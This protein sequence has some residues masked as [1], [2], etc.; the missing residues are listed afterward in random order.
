MDKLKNITAKKDN[1]TDQG[2]LERKRF[3]FIKNQNFFLIIIIIV[4]SVIVSFI[5]PN[6]FTYRNISNILQQVSVLGIATM[7]MGLL[8]LAGQLDL[9]IGA[10]MGLVGVI[11]VKMVKAGVSVELSVLAVLAIATFCGF[12]NGIIVAKSNVMPLIITLG[13]LYVYYGLALYIS[14][15][16]PNALG[17]YFR[18]LG[19][20][21]LGPKNFAIP[22]T[23]VVFL[24]I[25]LFAFAMNKYTKY[26]RRLNAIGGNRLTAYLAGINVDMH[27]ISLY[28]L[29]GL[30]MGLAGLVLTSRLGNVRAA[31][32]EG[33]ELKALAAV[34][35]GGITFEGGRGSL[36]GAFFG[37]VLL[38]VIYNAM[39]IIGVSSYFQ[40]MVLGAIIVVTTVISSLGK[41]KTSF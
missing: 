36:T 25:F 16:R 28:T 29:V 23:V 41:R 10:M 3:G 20:S 5:N 12:I 26:G 9:S 24:L 14:D 8:M 19:Q 32:G 33:Y 21:K 34:I 37:V 7:C 18:F 15:G 40:T 39:N 6:F 27:I 11:F 22:F 31:S 4:I 17:D 13:M 35:I 30:I 38:G 2:T 1:I